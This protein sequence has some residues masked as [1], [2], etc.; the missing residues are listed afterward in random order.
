MSPGRR[1]IYGSDETPHISNPISRIEMPIRTRD[2]PSGSI[3]ESTQR[4]LYKTRRRGNTGSP[5]LLNPSILCVRVRVR[6]GAGGLALAPSLLDYFFRD[7]RGRF[8]VVRE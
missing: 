1:P 3:A 5:S 2:F 4:R 7:R 8:L 6:L